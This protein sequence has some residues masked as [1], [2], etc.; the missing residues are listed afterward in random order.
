MKHTDMAVREI[1]DL[2]FDSK[3][4]RAFE[5]GK[6]SPAA[7]FKKI[8]ALLG[9][10]LGYKEFLPVWNEIFFAKHE[11]EELIASL[12][13]NIRLIMLSNINRLHYEYIVNTFP[14]A[15]NLFGIEN[16]IASF[17]TGFVKPAKEIYELAIK[18]AGMAKE[19]IVYVDDRLDLIEAASGYGI[20]SIPFEGVS[21]LRQEF[22]NLGIL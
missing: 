2:F 8:K 4:T 5:E 11:T 1:Y 18:K 14:S 7:F 16:V 3:L 10:R 22:K 12:P 20:R 19:S 9:L 15:I 21:K 6:I 17:M 13:S